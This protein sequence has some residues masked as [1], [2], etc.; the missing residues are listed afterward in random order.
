MTDIM[1][2]HLYVLAIALAVGF[3]FGAVWALLPLAF[4]LGFVAMVIVAVNRAANR[5]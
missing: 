4:G 1:V 3:A 2:G 5:R